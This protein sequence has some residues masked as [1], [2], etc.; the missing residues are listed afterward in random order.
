[1]ADA[2]R[3]T[4]FPYYLDRQSD[5]SYAVLNRNHKQIGVTTNEHVDYMTA[6]GRVRFKRMGPGTARALSHNGSEDLS[7]IYLYDDGSA[8]NRG[9]QALSAYLERLG[10]LMA[11]Q[12]E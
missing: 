12:I 1:M 8:P 6:P 11:L 9:P 7:R 5:G 2:L 10:R 4:H 3:K